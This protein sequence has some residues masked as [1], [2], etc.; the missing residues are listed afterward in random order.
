MQERDHLIG[1]FAGG[2]TWF[3]G[4]LGWN[5]LLSWFVYCGIGAVV[6]DWWIHVP[7]GAW[8]LQVKVFS[9]A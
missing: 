2:D 3:L 5:H 4:L 9:G 8:N 1:V 7:Q 6:R